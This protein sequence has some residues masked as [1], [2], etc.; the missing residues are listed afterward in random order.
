MILNLLSLACL[1]DKHEYSTHSFAGGAGC[2][3]NSHR[4]YSRNNFYA[5]NFRN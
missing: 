3:C 2:Q 4:R 5:P 1:S